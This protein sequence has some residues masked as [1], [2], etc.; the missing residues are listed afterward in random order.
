MKRTEA[1]KILELWNY[2]LEKLE[3][4]T[5]ENDQD[6]IVIHESAIKLMERDYAKATAI[7]K[8]SQNS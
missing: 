5:K 7:I 4:A 2:H 1:L 6:E 8:R 3:E